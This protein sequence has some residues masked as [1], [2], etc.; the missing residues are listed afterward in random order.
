MSHREATSAKKAAGDKFVVSL[1]RT[2]EDG[3]Y[4]PQQVCYCNK[5]G[6]FW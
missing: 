3:E 2:I 6:L 5:T 1:A 4:L